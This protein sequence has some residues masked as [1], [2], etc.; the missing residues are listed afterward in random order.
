[1]HGLQKKFAMIK[2]PGT[3][4]RNTF[5][6]IRK[7]NSAMGFAISAWN[8]VIKPVRIKNTAFA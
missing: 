3:S 2:V 4:L 8:Y 7:L 6:N 5:P 1:M